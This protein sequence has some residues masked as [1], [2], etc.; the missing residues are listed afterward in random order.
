MCVSATVSFTMGAVLLPLGVYSFQRA[1]QKAPSYTALS[2]FPLAF[3]IQQILEGIVWLT[4]DTPQTKLLYLA[5]YS[6]L[7]F[8]HLFWPAW[9]PYAV[10]RLEKRK[11]L[12]PVLLAFAVAGVIFGSLLY[13]PIPLNHWVEIEIEKGSIRYDTTLLYHRWLPTEVVDFFYVAIVLPPFFIVKDRLIRIFGGLLI[14]SLLIAFILYQYAF[15]S[16]WCFFVALLS[17]F[18]VFV[19][20]QRSK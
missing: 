7:F 18:I 2:V 15:A 11:N 1:Q 17:L 3:G 13:F 5:G 19:I 6:Y 16:V 20:Y 14:L 10:Y 12:K 9:A 4:V 8:S